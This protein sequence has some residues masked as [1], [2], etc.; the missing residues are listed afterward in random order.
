MKVLYIADFLYFTDG[1]AHVSACAH[2][3]TLIEMYGEENV[4][5]I[6]LTGQRDDSPL[7][8]EKAIIRGE[9]NKIKMWINCFLNYT[10]YLD[11]KGIQTILRIIL[12]NKYD[13]VFIDNS[14]FGLLTKKIK[15]TCPGL[16][17]ISYYHDV[18]ASLAQ[19]WKNK[20]NIFKK[21]VYQAMIN[22]EKINQAYCDVN[23]TLNPRESNLFKKYYGYLPELQLGVYMNII[24]DEQYKYNTQ[25]LSERLNILFVGSHYQPNVDGIKWYI[26]EVL[27]KLECETSLTIAG[28][29]MELLCNEIQDIP[30]NTKIMGHVDDLSELY[31][32]ADVVISP[33]FEGGGMKVK[34]THAIAY[35]KIV[36]GTD[37]SFE[38]YQENIEQDQWGKYFFRCNTAEEFANAILKI[39][40]DKTLKK[41]NPSILN[42]YKSFYSEEYAQ[43][44][45]Q[46]AVEMAQNKVR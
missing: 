24:L 28:S 46:Q 44:V 11:K 9:R 5:I 16:P 12:E 35:G 40:K 2:K 45:I 19:D 10:T 29:H 33:I 37:E 13:F 27:P 25:A 39:H 6:S 30:N 22:S 21:V 1:G 38:G 18:K 36:V 4:D 31:K 14:I 41:N 3:D 7:Y 20:A 43:S 15:K 23:L 17:I 26:K 42:Y 8:G 34:V 32:S